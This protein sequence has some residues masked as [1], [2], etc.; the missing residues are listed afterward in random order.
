MRQLTQ[1]PARFAPVV[2][3]LKRLRRRPILW[4]GVALLGLGAAIFGWP[5]VIAIGV[6][7]VLLALAPCALMCALG[8]CMQ[9]MNRAPTNNAEE[10]APGVSPRVAQPATSACCDDK[11]QNAPPPTAR[12]FIIF[13]GAVIGGLA[14]L[15]SGLFLGWPWLTA[16]GVAPLLV[17]LAPCIA[18]CALGLGACAMM[19]RPSRTPVNSG[20]AEAGAPSLANEPSDVQS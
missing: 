10:M 16:I 4:I 12:R 3:Q 6:A 14:A 18:M 5:W 7:P 20:V 8:L 17:S 11:L 1:T 9:G 15:V 13:G 2:G 19:A